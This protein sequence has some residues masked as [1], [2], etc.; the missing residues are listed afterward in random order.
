MLKNAALHFGLFE[1][2]LL[3]VYPYMHRP[4]QLEYLLRLGRETADITG[5]HVEVGCAHGA[6]TA[7]LKLQADD[8][9]GKRRHIAIDTF[10]GFIP[11]D[12]T[13]EVTQRGKDPRHYRAFGDNKR[14]WVEQ[15]LKL[16]GARGVELVQADCI[17]FDFSAIGKIAFCF[18]DVDLYLPVRATLNAVYPL[19]APGGIITVDDGNANTAWAGALEAYLEF[20]AQHNLP[21]EIVGGKLGIIRRNA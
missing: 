12:V 9:G 21:T 8:L 14:E 3:S 20:I 15:S 19:L 11:K 5:T 18:I 6:T 7:L 16:A 13:Y 4:V 17:Q 10:A 2:S 1:R